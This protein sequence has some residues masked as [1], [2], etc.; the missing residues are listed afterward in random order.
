MITRIATY[1]SPAA[2]AREAQQ[3]RRAALRSNRTHLLETTLA[4]FGALH[5]MDSA[6][7]VGFRVELFYVCVESPEL[8]LQRIRTRVASGGHHVPEPDVQRRFQRSQA[9]LSAAI[10]RSDEVRLYD[11]TNHEH[12]HREIAVM[13]SDVRWI[14]AEL[15]GWAEA[16]ISRNRP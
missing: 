13:T 4:G 8:A 9:S 10:S 16:A 12:P 3:Q 1:S 2:A 11:N 6:R 5:H 14:A 7:K 15:P